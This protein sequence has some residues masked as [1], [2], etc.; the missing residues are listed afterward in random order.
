[1]ALKTIFTN[2]EISNFVLIRTNSEIKDGEI[3][4][5]PLYT[6]SPEKR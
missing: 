5:N 1:L 2:S 3:K 6:S 4:D